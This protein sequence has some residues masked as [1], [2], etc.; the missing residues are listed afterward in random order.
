MANKEEGQTNIDFRE[1]VISLIF[2]AEVLKDCL[3]ENKLISSA[4]FIKKV[5][6]LREKKQITFAPTTR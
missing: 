6:L 4:D 2:E 1:L 3:V 5:N